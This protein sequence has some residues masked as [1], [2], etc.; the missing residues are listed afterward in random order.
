MM[1]GHTPFRPPW[2]RE[3]MPIFWWLHHSAYRRFIS[4][5]LT[6]LFVAYAALLLLVEAWVV[7]LGERFH[8][9][10]RAWLASAPVL[11]WHSLVVLA[12]LFHTVTWLHL[13]PRALVIRVGG[14]VLPP[15]VVVA[16]HYAAW[17]G[18]TA[19]LAALLWGG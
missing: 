6:S 15:A 8:A 10:F 9:A 3:R 11:L 2:H 17:A 14:R 13:A 18:A 5:E 1:R 12:L 16:G 7:S 19:V 4:R